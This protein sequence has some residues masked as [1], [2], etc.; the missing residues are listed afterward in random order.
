[1][2]RIIAFDVNETLLDLRA[3]DPD[4]AHIFGDAIATREWFSQM[5]Q[6]ALLRMLRGGGEIFS[7]AM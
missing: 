6:S 2:A 5:I 3:L 1:M 7:R 4:F